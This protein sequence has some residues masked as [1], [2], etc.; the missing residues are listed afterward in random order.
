MLSIDD[1]Q[2][3][4]QTLIFLRNKAKETKSKQALSELMLFERHCIDQFKYL[5]FMRTN[6]YK[7]FSNYDD[8]NQDGLEAL[9]KAMKNYDPK[10]G[11]FFYWAHQYI[12]TRIARN[13][14][15]HTTIRFPLK[16][17]KINK[18]H[19][20]LKLPILID[21]NI[22]SDYFVENKEMNNLL[23]LAMNNLST[24]QKYIVKLL[25]GIDNKKPLSINKISHKL[26]I[27]RIKCLQKLHQAMEILKK[28]MNEL[29]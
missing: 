10:K 26:K 24:Q 3:L 23:H 11:I 8:L 5:V 7:S 15:Q 13:A 9:V 1:A 17:A 22:S 27:S 6:R 25:Y 16:F 29:K 12:D 2:K 20:E 28:C 19:K 18:P 4:M 21:N 14:N